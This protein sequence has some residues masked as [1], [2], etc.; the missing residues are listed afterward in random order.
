VTWR[1]ADIGDLTG[2][3]GVV[4]GATSGLGAV[5]A[6]ELAGHGAHVVLTAR[7]ER[8]G[9]ATV[10]RLRKAA[11]EASVEV[12]TLDLASLGSV[13]AFAAALAADHPRLDLLVNNA[14]VMATPF[15]RTEDGF[16]LQIA[17]NHLGPF[18][19][20]GRLLPL[21]AAAPAGR[22]VTV[23]SLAHQ[24]GGIDLD[25][26]TYERRRYVR[27]LAYGETKLANLL[28]AFELDRRLRAAGST[29]ASLAAHPGLARTRLGRRGGGPLAWLQTVGIILA[30][31]T[32]QSARRGAE[33]QLR[34]ATDPDMPGGAY[35]GPG[36]PG[37]ARGP[38]VIVGCSTL[39]RDAP[40][41]HALWDLSVG[42]TGVDPGLAPAFAPPPG[43]R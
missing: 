11:P 9:A 34:A 12:R 5:T 21:L 29:V 10:D 43:P 37:E 42:L 16:E 7:D 39:A 6:R 36:G 14:G 33:P 32:H 8:R 1:P 18:A 38:A 35:L 28:F 15:R 27:W 20:T 2:R 17:T 40:L 4:T 30:Q 22:V 26:L 23:A 25:D 24:W 19:L 3:V 41:A 31:P 13:E